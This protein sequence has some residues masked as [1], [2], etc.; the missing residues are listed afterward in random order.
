MLKT[1]NLSRKLAA[2]WQ[3]FT[4]LNMSGIFADF[5]HVEDEKLQLQYIL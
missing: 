4:P 2:A 5:L 1:Q 3:I